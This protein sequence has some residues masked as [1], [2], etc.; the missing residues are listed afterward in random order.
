[1]D[2]QIPD[3]VKAEPPKLGLFYVP[4]SG[5]K[6]GGRVRGYNIHNINRNNF[7]QWLRDLAEEA[8]VEVRYKSKLIGLNNKTDYELLVD[9]RNGEF[10]TMS[11]YLVGADGAR[12]SVRGLLF[13]NEKAPL[14]IVGQ[15]HWKAEGDF[16]DCFYGF[17]RDDLSIAYAYLIPKGDSTII[18]LGALP[19]Q[20]PSIAEL[21]ERFKEWLTD[22]FSFA[23]KS[24]IGKDAWA[25]PFGYFIPGNDKALLVGDAAGL[26]N[27]LSG[28]G[29]RLAVESAE[30]AASAITNPKTQDAPLDSYARDIR[31]IAQ[32]VGE[33]N[34]FVRQLDN[35]GREAFVREELSRK[36]IR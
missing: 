36:A 12:S 16:E 25:I 21:L 7:D 8:G 30:A 1:V 23:A 15:E 28:E 35:P 9:S 24:L 10:A 32:M 18:G 27:P 34:L 29:I 13:P 33:L 26:C 11:E 6:N 5:R 2:A 3:D 20:E 4:P 31:G 22:E 19:H 17:F 14:L